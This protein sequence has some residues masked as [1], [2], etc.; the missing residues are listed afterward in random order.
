MSLGDFQWSTTPLSLQDVGP[1]SISACMSWHSLGLRLV[2]LAPSVQSGNVKSQWGRVRCWLKPRIWSFF[3]AVICV[4]IYIH[5]YICIY[6]CRLASI[7]KF[8]FIYIYTISTNSHYRFIH[9]NHVYIH[10]IPYDTMP[11]QNIPY[12]TAH[13]YVHWL[14]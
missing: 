10:A 7:C 9:T 8:Y 5:M 2:F 6:L 14:S 3:S 12:H 11:D 4:Y 13:R 1:G